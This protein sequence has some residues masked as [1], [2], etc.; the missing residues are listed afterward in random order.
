[1]SPLRR[2]DSKRPA[3]WFSYS[4]EKVEVAFDNVYISKNINENGEK[5]AEIFISLD[6][7]KLL[8]H[9][10]AIPDAVFDNFPDKIIRKFKITDPLKDAKFGL[11]RY[12]MDIRIADRSKEFIKAKMQI[13]EKALAA[14]KTDQSKAINL[15]YDILE[16]NFLDNFVIDSMK[17][18]QIR[19][20][21]HDFA[22]FNDSK[23]NQMVAVAK[24][25]SPL[26][27]QGDF[28]EYDL[29]ETKTTPN[30]EFPRSDALD[31]YGSDTTTPEK[32]DELE[33]LLKRMQIKLAN[34]F[35]Q[36][37]MNP[38]TDYTTVSGFSSPSSVKTIAIMFD[39]ILDMAD[40]MPAPMIESAILQE[41]DFN[42][43]GLLPTVE[44]ATCKEGEEA[45]EV[46]DIDDLR[47]IQK[48]NPYDQV[49]MQK[50]GKKL[51]GYITEKKET[52][53]SLLEHEYLSGYTDD[54]MK[55]P[56]WITDENLTAADEGKEF[57]FRKKR[58]NSSSEK[59]VYDE[60]FVKKV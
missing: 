29:T 12:E 47:I 8:K 36:T 60:F 46:L 34:L 50:K 10:S 13:I 33:A 49:I 58:T 53:E 16:S 56:I 22:I 19:A 32:I 5:T 7:I 51:L 30:L 27:I 45:L 14:V 25:F 9:C 59:N 40:F 43:I 31:L 11:L 55:N 42:F 26:N 6:Y 28:V 44:D 24:E 48:E 39:E 15:L 41:F 38:D 4:E 2:T 18:N 20:K 54:V 35:G 23:S 52:S 1:M 57:L 37:N 17:L 3:D 21:N